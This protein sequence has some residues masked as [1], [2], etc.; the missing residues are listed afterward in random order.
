MLIVWCIHSPFVLLTDA[1]VSQSGASLS[2][3]SWRGVRLGDQSP[4]SPSPSPSPAS[5]QVSHQQLQIKSTRS[6]TKQVII[7]AVMQHPS[8]RCCLMS[9]LILNEMRLLFFYSSS[10]AELPHCQA[11]F[12]RQRHRVRSFNLFTVQFI[13]L[14]APG[15]WF[16]YCEMECPFIICMTPDWFGVE[17]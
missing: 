9:S 2:P 5:L 14:S 15:V 17:I 10:K 13:V 7:T 1:I 4:P 12:F 8:C 16:C 6:I 11:I 3:P